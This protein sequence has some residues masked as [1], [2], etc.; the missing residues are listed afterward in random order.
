MEGLVSE[1]T[2]TVSLE[3][4]KFWSVTHFGDPPVQN[5]KCLIP[6]YDYVVLHWCCD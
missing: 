5:Y 1:M 3:D 2:Y 6:G 4:V